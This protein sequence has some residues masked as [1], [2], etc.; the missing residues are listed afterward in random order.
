MEA[1]HEIERIEHLSSET[2]YPYEYGRIVDIVG[3]MF[4]ESDKEIIRILSQY[5]HR[6]EG[7]N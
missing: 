3:A 6:Q 4:D 5:L 2:P 1:F 7:E